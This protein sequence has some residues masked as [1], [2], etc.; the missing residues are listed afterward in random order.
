MAT[1]ECNF[2]EFKKAAAEFFWSLP[3]VDVE[4]AQHGHKCLGIMYLGMEGTPLEDHQAALTLNLAGRKL[5]E[6]EVQ[7]TPTEDKPR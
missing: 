6:K 2:A 3:E 5:M 4:Q 7:L 1:I